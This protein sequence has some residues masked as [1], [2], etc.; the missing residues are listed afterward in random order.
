MQGSQYDIFDIDQQTG[1]K[2]KK[3]NCVF[4][5]LVHDYK[6]VIWMTNFPLKDGKRLTHF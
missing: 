5:I 1:I 4:V 2:T 6:R 3:N